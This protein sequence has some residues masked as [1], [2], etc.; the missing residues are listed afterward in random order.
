MTSKRRS[1]AAPAATPEQLLQQAQ[2]RLTGA[3]DAA[4]LLARDAAALADAAGELHALARAQLLIGLGLH[5]EGQLPKAQASLTR[6]QAL[7]AHLDDPALEAWAASA[8]GVVLGE[9]GDVT[10]AAERLEAAGALARGTG[11]ADVRARVLTAQ[12]QLHLLLQEAPAALAAFDEA[13]E[14]LAAPEGRGERPDDVPGDRLSAALHRAGTLRVLNRQGEALREFV[15]LLEQARRLTLPRLVAAVQAGLAQL[16]MEL[17]HLNEAERFSDAV[18][19][20]ARP[21]LDA[22]VGALITQAR[23]LSARGMADRAVPLLIRAQTQAAEL[24]APDR[25]AEALEAL[26]AAYEQLQRWPE[27]LAAARAHQAAAAA[28]QS[29]VLE[30]R[31]QV[32]VWRAGWEHEAQRTQLERDRLEALDAA[33]AELR[34]VRDQLE[35]GLTHDPLTGVLNRVTLELEVNR[36]LLDDPATAFEMLIVRIEQLR[37]VVDV[38]GLDVGDAALVSLAR[39]LEARVHAEDAAGLVG[40]YAEHDFAVFRRAPSGERAVRAAAGA[41]LEDLGRPV[42]AE[43]QALNLR[44]SLGIAQ[45]PRHGVTFA[46]LGQRAA[47]ALQDAGERSA[48]LGVYSARMGRLA[49]ER[50]TIHHSLHEALDRDELHLHYQPIFE[51]E[52]LTPVAV[53][54]LARWTHPKLGE[55][56]PARFVPVAEASD[57]IF[58]LGAW[59]MRRVHKDLRRFQGAAPGLQASVNVSPRQF[60]FQGYPAQVQAWLAG[61]GLRPE[62]VILEVT[63]GAMAEDV[64]LERYAA[65]RETG[66]RLAIDDVGQ[67]YSSLTRLYQ[68]QANVLKLDQRLIERLVAG[69]GQRDSRRLVAALIEFGLGSGMRIVAEGVESE[70]QLAALREMGCTHAQGYLLSRPLPNASV[71]KLLKGRAGA[72]GAL[73]SAMRL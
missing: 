3:P 16:H 31:A 4:L 2:A 14:L 73:P 49:R 50:L 57:L 8:L 53:E 7:A 26:S 59:V 46:E 69:P 10:G 22:R 36:R 62:D 29:R 25:A 13:L 68:V 42:R 55:V 60:G 48:H 63:E 23:T 47:L 66:V 44:A 9:A 58:D 56:S 11:Q 37:P 71:T 43:G 34:Q 40:R 28:A 30:Q 12:G 70:A 35:F 20:A 72:G 21:P 1:P 5:A 67:A 45:Y 52:G 65:L 51:L 61:S 54:A 38:L 18:L 39:R 19:R 41:L 24:P 32:E 17:G 64:A 6:A 33:Q 27:A 15:R